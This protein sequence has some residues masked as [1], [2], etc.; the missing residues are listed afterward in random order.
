MKNNTATVA[1]ITLKRAWSIVHTQKNAHI[2]KT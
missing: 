1:D 2:Q